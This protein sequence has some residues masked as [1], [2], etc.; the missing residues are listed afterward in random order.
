MNA[1]DTTTSLASPTMLQR[2]RDF[3][4]V[5]ARDQGRDPNTASARKAAEDFVSM[6]FVQPLLAQLRETNNA[7]EP[8]APG[9]AERQFGELMDQVLSKQIVRA[10]SFPLV[11]RIESD[12]SER[13][14]QLEAMRSAG[15]GRTVS[16]QATATR[17]QGVLA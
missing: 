14:A 7:A 5:I 10:S 8:F 9:P 6:A 17:T 3:S 1:I 4:S 2:Q 15:S 13:S 12:L 16:A 11:E